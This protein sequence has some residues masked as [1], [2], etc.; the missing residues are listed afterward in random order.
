[1]TPILVVSECFWPEG[2]GGT[3]ATYLITKLLA[4]ERDINITVI[5][6][7]RNPA[8]ISNVKFI[9]DPVLRSPNKPKLLFNFARPSMKQRY[10]GLMRR[11][12]TIYIPYGYPVIPIAKESG[13]KVVVHLHDYQPVVYNSTILFDQSISSLREIAYE[14]NYELLEHDSIKRA[15]LG[16]ILSIVITHVYRTW[17]CEADTIICVS[18]KQA[19]I[20]SKLAPELAHKIKVIYNPLP[21]I[22]HTEDKFRQ[23]TFVYSGGGS[24]IKG[25][26][27]FIRGALNILKRGKNADF[28][29]LGRSGHRYE[30]LIE[31][32]SANFKDRFNFLGHLPYEDALRLYSKSHAV[33]VPSICEETFSYVVIESMLAGTIPIASR[34]GGISEIVQGTYAEEFLFEP[35]DA[36]ELTDKMEMILSMSK[37]EIKNGGL[38]LREA[39]QKKFNKETIQEELLKVLLG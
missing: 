2:S 17:T 14:L 4:Q 34:I 5:T 18:H 35:G 31:R 20:V 16:S 12:D 21:E 36:D 6:G 27:V 38:A 25:F 32:L 26:H 39:V 33:L 19:K 3:L 30:K 23:S 24:Y 22:P 7:T 11:F 29:L 1:M 8:P 37:E 15:L 28:L 13:K 9:V 10:K